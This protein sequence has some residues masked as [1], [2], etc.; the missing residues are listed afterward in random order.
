M[1]IG[2]GIP[3][4]G[5]WAQPSYQVHL[6]RLAEDLNYH[7][8][9]V[10]QRLVNPAG[11]S[12]TT[13]TSVPDP[14]TTLAYLAARTDRVRLGVA[15]VNM[16]FI[17][18]ALLAK[19]AITID[20]LSGGRLDLGLGNG[21]MRQEFAVSGV[22]MARRGA[23]AEEYLSVLHSLFTDEVSSFDGEFYS[24]PPVRLE[25]KPVQQPG[26][27]ILLGGHSEA[28]LR[29]VGRR[30]DGWISA[31]GA[32][33][34]TL[35]DSIDIVKQAAVEAGRDPQALRFICRGALGVGEAGEDR[36]LLHGSLDQ[37]RQDLTVLAEAGV[38]EVFF[39]LN[40]DPRIGGP[41]VDPA[42]AVREAERILEALAP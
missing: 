15:I 34:S 33:L 10:L 7:S 13:Y 26:P 36:R 39:D 35:G 8:V 17:S 41:D 32:D 2:L 3:S 27:P 30:A 31:S 40:F 37:V 16:P 25:P 24:F 19:Q 42:D 23:R 5:A 38:T 20:H 12:D 11:S 1:Q 14:L 28:N 21:W 9:W 4:T 6:A 18:P 29:R 22:D